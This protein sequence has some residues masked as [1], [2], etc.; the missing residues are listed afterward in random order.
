MLKAEKFDFVNS[1]Y[2]FKTENFNSQETKE[3]IKKLPFKD[4]TKNLTTFYSNNKKLES[5]DF[6]DLR[7]HIDFYVMS[8]VKN[9]LN[10]NNFT[11]RNSWFQ[12]Y[13][14]NNYHSLHVH[15][16]ESFEFSYVFYVQT[17]DDSSE[18]KFYNPG[19]PYC[20]YQD[21]VFTP[22]E[23]DLLIFNSYVSHEVLPNNDNERISLAGNIQ[24]S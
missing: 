22:H 14:T 12:A 21:Y 13:K 5:D 6:R 8:F 16:L 24:V 1:F 4:F 3:K 18:I 15:G 11:H 23:N 10:K 20:Y 7:K 9:I 19:Y 2:L 17:S